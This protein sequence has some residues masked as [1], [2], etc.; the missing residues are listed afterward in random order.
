[1]GQ[2]KSQTAIRVIKLTKSPTKG[3]SDARVFGLRNIRLQCQS[4]GPLSLFLSGYYTGVIKQPVERPP[5]TLTKTLSNVRVPDL[6]NDGI[7]DLVHDLLFL[8]WE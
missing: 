5:K 4:L 7:V 6:R 3:V 2:K 1:M 8:C